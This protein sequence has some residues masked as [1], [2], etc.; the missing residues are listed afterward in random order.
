MANQALKNNQSQKSI[1]G[2]RGVLVYRQE[3]GYKLVTMI[4]DMY[5][6]DEQS[7]ITIWSH[8][9]DTL[10]YREP[11]HVNALHTAFDLYHFRVADDAN[12][13]LL[14]KRQEGVS[15]AYY[16][17]GATGIEEYSSFLWLDVVNFRG[18]IKQHH[19]RPHKLDHT[20]G[21]T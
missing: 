4:I 3:S 16:T 1:E 18:R 10:E 12:I 11:L 20:S 21:H 9:L 13:E 2:Y 7:H 17:V 14:I 6:P 15:E 19:T 8:N 5:T